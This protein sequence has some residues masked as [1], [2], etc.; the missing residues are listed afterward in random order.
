MWP[1]TYF[2]TGMVPPN[3]V[4]LVTHWR[5]LDAYIGP[6]YRLGTVQYKVQYMRHAPSNIR[7]II[8]YVDVY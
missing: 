4:T 1:L 2:P 3:I 8:L 6:T 7:L 5:S